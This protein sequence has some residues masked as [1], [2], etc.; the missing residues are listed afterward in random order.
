MTQFQAIEG[1]CQCGAVRYRVTGPA[2]HLFHCHC[3]MCRRVHGT[4][5]ATF[6]TIP[7]GHLV[8]EA[9]A[10]MLATFESSPGVL[11]QHCRRCGCQLFVEDTAHPRIRGYAPGTADGHPGHPADGALHIFVA[12]KVAWHEITDGLPQFD[13]LPPEYG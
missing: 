13:E 5:F 4:V 6:A 3:S 9:G 2:E 1:R 8:V 7:R 11:R 10:D 12:S